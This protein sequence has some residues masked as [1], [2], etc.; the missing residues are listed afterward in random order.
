[1]IGSLINVALSITIEATPFLVLGT[2]LATLVRKWKFF[3]RAIHKMPSN[4]LLR[5]LIAATLGVFMPVCECGNVPMTRSLMQKGFSKAEATTFLL[6]APVLNPITFIT[7][8][9]AFRLDRKSTRL[10]SSH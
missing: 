9:E 1:M 8:S 5:R 7:T 6:A 3:D 10:N 2:L 4:T